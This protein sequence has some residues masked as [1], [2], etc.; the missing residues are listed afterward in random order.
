V[1]SDDAG[2]E[3][4]NNFFNSSGGGSNGGDPWL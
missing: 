1:A 2:N 3:F 4:I